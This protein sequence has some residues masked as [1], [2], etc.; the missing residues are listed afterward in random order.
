MQKLWRYQVRDP[1]HLVRD[2]M[3]AIPW[4]APGRYQVAATWFLVPWPRFP[5]GA[6]QIRADPA[7]A[8]Q[9]CRI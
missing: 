7:G 3:A 9:I 5:A 8:W 2:P 1:W 6:W 4:P